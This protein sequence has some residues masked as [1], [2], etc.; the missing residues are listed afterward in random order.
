MQVSTGETF[1]SYQDALDKGV[2]T[3]DLVMVEGD[4]LALQKLV[5]ITRQAAK[6]RKARKG[7]I[8]RESRRRN[9]PT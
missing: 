5:R 2:L 3:S 8:E 1:A 7:R 6:E 9:R 4:R